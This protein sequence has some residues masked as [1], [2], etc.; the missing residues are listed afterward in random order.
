MNT[1]LDEK[2]KRVKNQ[3][4]LP[5]VGENFMNIPK[6]K[7]MLIVGES[8][9]HDN[10]QKSID[11]HNSPDFTR[12]VINELAIGRR[13]W[14]TKIFP[15]LHRAMFGNDE[16]NSNLFWNLTSFYNFIQRPMETNK[17]R[18]SRK[19]FFS[20]WLTFFDTLDILKPNSCLFI[21][22]EASN[23]LRDAIT[24]SDFE[25]VNFTKD[26]KI[27]RT[28]PRRATLKGVDGELTKLIFIQHTSQYF[29]W[30]KWNDYLKKKLSEQLEWFDKKLNE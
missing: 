15:N 3:K 19:D 25:I 14:R 30:T 16:F 6:D 23:S 24:E 20:G 22:T 26:D 4:W 10:S 5:F 9:Y 18:P 27:S 11:K 12:Q 17:S 13:Y 21:G 29:S 1:T 8:H 28:Y 2:F 7:R